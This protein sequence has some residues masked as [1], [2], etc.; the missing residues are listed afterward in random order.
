MKRVRRGTITLHVP[1]DDFRRP[2]A[3]GWEKVSAEIAVAAAA[4]THW[5]VS[6]TPA[7]TY[8]LLWRNIVWLVAGLWPACGRLV[9]GL[10]PACGRL[11]TVLRLAFEGNLASLRPAFRRHLA[12][13]WQHC[14]VF[15]QAFL[16]CIRSVAFPGPVILI[17]SSL[18]PC[19][20]TM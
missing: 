9:A 19:S 11:M 16:F 6:F 3:R 15:Y 14:R 17:P 8:Q 4:K 2:A 13:F 5:S 20:S 7:V 10:R 1:V 12:G 18:I